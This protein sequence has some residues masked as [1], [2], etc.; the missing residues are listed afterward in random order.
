[1]LAFIQNLNFTELAIIAIVAVL[2][3]GRRLPEVAGQAARG[4]AKAKRTLQELRRQSGLDEELTSFRQSVAEARQVVEDEAADVYAAPR[5]LDRP[6]TSV[7][8]TANR[9]SPSETSG[10]SQVYGPAMPAAPAPGARPDEA[11][12]RS[13]S[14]PKAD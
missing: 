7:S 4:I 10:E 1:V 12:P 2:V 5:L 9:P 8:R 11:A 14:E 3:F 6:T 13:D